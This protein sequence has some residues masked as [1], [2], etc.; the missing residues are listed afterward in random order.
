MA[1]ATPPAAPARKVVLVSRG[2]EVPGLAALVDTWLARGVL[3]VGVVGTHAQA[4][5][6]AIDRLCIGDGSNPRFLLT[7]SHHAEE[8]LDDAIELARLVAEVEGVALGED[9]EVVEA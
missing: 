1:R 7:A 8:S 5:E 2:R 9:I 3:Y 6:D 4:I